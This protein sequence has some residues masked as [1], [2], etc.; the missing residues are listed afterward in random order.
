V[1]TLDTNDT[2]TLTGVTKAQ[3][4]TNHVDDFRFV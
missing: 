4:V 3:L 1:I 2:I